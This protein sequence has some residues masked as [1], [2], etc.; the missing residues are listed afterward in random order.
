[1]AAMNGIDSYV[2]G[3]DDP[4]ISEAI[5]SGHYVYISGQVSK[6]PNGRFIHGDFRTQASNVFAN[7]DRILTH[8]GA[9]KRQ[10]VA[11]VVYIVDFRRHVDEVNAVRVEYYGDHRPT[12]TTVGVT[13]LFFAGQL[14]E[15]SLVVDLTLPA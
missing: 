3:E 6:R 12:N 2:H 14:L 9:T 4:S 5:R 11:E 1:M 15:I 13:D 7:I 10:V 8:Y